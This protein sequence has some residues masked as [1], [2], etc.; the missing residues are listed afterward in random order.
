MCVC[1]DR[2]VVFVRD[3]IIRCIRFLKPCSVLPFSVSCFFFYIIGSHRD[4]EQGGIR[5]VRV[6]PFFFPEKKIDGGGVCILIKHAKANNVSELTPCAPR[7]FFLWLFFLWW[8][9]L[10]AIWYPPL[11]LTKCVFFSSPD[12]FQIAT[13]WCFFALVPKREKALRWLLYF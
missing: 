5:L 12:A 2:L 10:P 4:R 1:V 11:S 9:A 6:G 3:L 13:V 8:T 7:S